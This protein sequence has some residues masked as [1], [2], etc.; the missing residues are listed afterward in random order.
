MPKPENPACGVCHAPARE[1][2]T[3]SIRGKALEKALCGEH[4]EELL[5]G[6]RTVR[7]RSGD[8]EDPAERWR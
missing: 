8:S 3:L 7:R 4:L 6:A 5:S 2:V 1:T